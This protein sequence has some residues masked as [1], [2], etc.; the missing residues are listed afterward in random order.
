[1]SDWMDDPDRSRGINAFLVEFAVRYMRE[2]ARLFGDDYDCAMIFLAVLEANGRHNIRQ[3]YFRDEYAD[4]RDSLP[5]EMARPVS[6]KA[7]SESLGMARETLRRKV[8]ALIE[9]GYLVEDERGGVITARGIIAHEEFLAA[10]RNVLGF[11][12]RLRTDLRRYVAP[13]ADLAESAYN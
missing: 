12:R 2:A 7:I 11:L 8:R 4:V 6:R 1:M 9:R 13:S 10:Q 5:A 3:A